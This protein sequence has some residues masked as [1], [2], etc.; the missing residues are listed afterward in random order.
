MYSV[1]FVVPR[2]YHMEYKL[3]I[4]YKK[5]ELLEGFLGKFETG[6]IIPGGIAVKY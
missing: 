6:D 3:L 2:P 1:S 4:G 5:T